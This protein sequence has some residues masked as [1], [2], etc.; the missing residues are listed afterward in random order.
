MFARC[1]NNKYKGKT[2]LKTMERVG[3]SWLWSPNH[4]FLGEKTITTFAVEI[5]SMKVFKGKRFEE[6]T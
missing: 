6:E 3:Y 5:D 2:L 4:N 1:R